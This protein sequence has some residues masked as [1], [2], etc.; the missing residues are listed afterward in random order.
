MKIIYAIGNNIDSHIQLSR[1]L[2][3]TKHD[4]KVLSV[5]TSN[6]FDSDLNI[7]FF[8]NYISVSDPRIEFLNDYIKKY[9]PD[10]IISDCEYI[11][12]YI[13]FN[14]KIPCINYSIENLILRL[15][16]F[17]FDVIRAN[18]LHLNLYKNADLNLLPVIDGIDLK[19]NPLASFTECRPFTFVAE[20]Q[21]ETNLVHVSCNNKKLLHRANHFNYNQI[22]TIE[23]FNS[24]NSSTYFVCEFLYTFVMDAYYNNRYLYVYDSFQNEYSYLFSHMEKNRFAELFKSENNFSKKKI[25]FDINLKQLSDFIEEI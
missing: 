25:R 1:F 3:I 22:D 9:N 13:G 17:N 18:P 4:V 11:I 24:I 16:K 6:Y 15:K 5:G 12:P 2:K 14:L 8:K 23:Y 10:L 21:N 7:A 20:N 19:A